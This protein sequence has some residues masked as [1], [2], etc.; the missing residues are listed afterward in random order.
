MVLGVLVGLQAFVSPSYAAN[1]F[2]VGALFA[3]PAGFLEEIGW[4]GYAF[5]KMDTLGNPFAASVL[6][7][8]LWA[9]WHLPVIDYLGAASPHKA[10]LLPFFLA[11]TLILTAM[12]VLICWM[13]THAKSV[14]LTQLMHISSTGSLV[15]FGPPRVSALEEVIWYG[16]YG[17]T[18]WLAV[19]ILVGNRF[20]ESGSTRSPSVKHG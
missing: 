9:I 17:G 1:R 6:L 5:P 2:F 4:T 20:D 8:L 10:Y 3:L 19:A 7:G 15:V 14:L 11:F 12:R 18:A 13:Y 16:V